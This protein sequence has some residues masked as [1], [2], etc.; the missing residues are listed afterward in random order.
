MGNLSI[1]PN[2]S[3]AMEYLTC[4]ITE[5]RQTALKALESSL[6]AQ[7][8]R[9]LR[10]YH[11]RRV[12]VRLFDTNMTNFVPSNDGEAAMVGSSMNLAV[13]DLKTAMYRIKDLYSASTSNSVLNAVL[14]P[15]LVAAQLTAL[16]DAIIFVRNEGTHVYT[17]LSLSMVAN[18]R[19]LTQ[20]ST[21][22]E[23]CMRTVSYQ[24]LMHLLVNYH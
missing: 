5:Q 18:E 7:Y 23:G 12:T 4:K 13:G 21:I 9:V 3:I 19:E 10:A 17:T 16:F 14:F 6:K 11:K 1:T 15:D 20:I 24:T 22:I 2:P 8:S